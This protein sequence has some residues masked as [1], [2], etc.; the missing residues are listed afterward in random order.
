MMMELEELLHQSRGSLR[1]Y[2]ISSEK[3]TMT[4]L[5]H[6]FPVLTI[7]TMAVRRERPAMQLFAGE[8]ELSTYQSGSKP[9]EI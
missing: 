8:P 7:H 1:S 9:E 4:K 6:V 3:L 2:V 5:L